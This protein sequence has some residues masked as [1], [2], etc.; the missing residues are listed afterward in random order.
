MLPPGQG[1]PCPRT[2]QQ[3]AQAE[4]GGCIPTAVVGL[5]GGA[6]GPSPEAAPEAARPEAWQG[7]GGERP[8]VGRAGAGEFGPGLGDRRLGRSVP[9]AGQQGLLRRN[10]LGSGS[11]GTIPR[12]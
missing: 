9:A 11:A 8:G 1:L 4:R 10:I 6:G 5:P 3:A 12:R 7:G 2:W